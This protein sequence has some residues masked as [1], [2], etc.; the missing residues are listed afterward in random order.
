[1]FCEK[2]GTK[3][4]KGNKFCEKCGNAMPKQTNENKINKEK[5]DNKL[6]ELKK[7]PKKT[8]I[9][10][11]IVLV[12]VIVAI[13]TLCILLNNPVK[14]VEDSLQNY[15]SN[16][17]N[18]KK[19]L[20]EIGKVL[21]SNKNDEK[22]LKKIKETSHKAMEK[23]VKNFNTEYKD[24]ESLEENYKK[25]SGALS[26]IYNYF[27]NSTAKEYML[28]YDLYVKYFEEL[29]MLYNS[30]ECYFEAKEYEN[31]ND[32]YYA[33]Y[34][35]QRVEKEDSYYKTAKKYIDEYVKDEINNLKEQAESYIKITDES[36]NQEILKCYLAKLS[37]ILEKKISNYIDLSSTDDYKEL[38]N[39]TSKK[40]VEYTKK[41]VEELD[42]SLD[43][44]K[45]LEYTNSALALLNND[46]DEYKEIAELK[47]KYEDKKPDKLTEK[48]VVSEKGARYSSRSI[49]IG[50]EEYNS[51]ISFSF[52]GE[53][54]SIVYRLNNE[55]AKLKTSIVRGENWDKSFNGYFVIKGDDKQLYKSEKITKTG[56]FKAEIELDLKGV[57]DL[58]IEFVTESKVDFWSTFNIYL[59]EPYLY[60]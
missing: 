3:N 22:V 38:F 1:M 39:E 11:S 6:K 25:V 36:T 48:Y 42:Q 58:R 35:Y 14:K 10:M 8:K 28:D 46:S 51:F 13:I 40:V 43:Y 27:K 60:K 21:K 7:L 44:N 59:V 30:K 5:K 33:Y 54:Q 49:V 19:E 23:W 53:T 34:Y 45:A 17:D 41:V 50:K 29:N 47:Q 24:K 18:S 57:D 9:I 55:Y 15:Y 37:Y 16:Y 4:E 52:E 26:D 2:C 32:E 56:E 31:K 12:I 20:E